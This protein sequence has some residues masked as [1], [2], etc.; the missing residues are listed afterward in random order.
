MNCSPVNSH[1]FLLCLAIYGIV[2]RY[3]SSL[4]GAYYVQVVSSVYSFHLEH[5]G[6]GVILNSVFLVKGCVGRPHAPLVLLALII[7]LYL[8]W[9]FIEVSTIMLV[10]FLTAFC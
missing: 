9:F 1:H 3:F 2:F 7:L 6:F 8:E 5:L 4:I 10:T